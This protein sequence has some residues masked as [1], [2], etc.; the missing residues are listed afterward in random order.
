MAGIKD[1][2]EYKN[3]LRQK[4]RLIRSKMPKQEKLQRDVDI[5]NKFFKLNRYHLCDTVLTYVSTEI[6]VDTR[7]IIQRAWDDNKRVAV[8]Y[9]VPGTRNIEFYYINSF[10]ELKTGTFGVLEPAP[11][12][13][14]LFKGDGISVCVVPAFCFDKRGYRLGYGKGY[15]DRFLSGYNGTAVG[16]CYA[17]CLRE[18]LYHGHFDYAVNIVV[19]ESNIINTALQTNRRKKYIGALN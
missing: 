1:I 6:E 15:Y 17:S 19:T 13:D 10:D 5:Q 9:C 2:R 14:K 16:I 3:N 8:P 12:P 7:N 18:H 4:Y 11:D